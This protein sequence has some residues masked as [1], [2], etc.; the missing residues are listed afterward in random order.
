MTI[1]L[2]N[3]TKRPQQK[4]KKKR[5]GRGNASGKGTYSG[6]GIKGQRSRSGGK[7]GLFRRSIMRQLVKKIPKLSGFKSQKRQRETVTLLQ[8]QNNYSSGELVNLISLKKK[9]IIPR[10]ATSAK[11]VATGMLSKKLIIENIPLSKGAEKIVKSA[12]G[13]IK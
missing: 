7:K 11:I 4:H 12:G 1:G 2:H 8:L 6:K 9:Q 10:K 5:I 3:L 13:E